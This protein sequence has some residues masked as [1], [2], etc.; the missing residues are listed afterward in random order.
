MASAQA[1]RTRK[2]RFMAVVEGM[3]PELL[4]AHRVIVSE[5][6]A[7]VERRDF[8][9]A[10]PAAFLPSWKNHRPIYNAS[11]RWCFGMAGMRL[12]TKS[13]IPASG[14]GFRRMVPAWWDLW[15][16]LDFASS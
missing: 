16:P 3:R 12:H 10:A 1:R 11:A 2:R 14:I 8:A 5:K 15:M 9:P 7:H 13:S 4:R 6:L